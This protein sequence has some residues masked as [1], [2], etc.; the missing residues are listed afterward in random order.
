MGTH[1]RRAKK[2]VQQ[3]GR[4]EFDDEAPRTEVALDAFY[5]ARYPL[6]NAQYHEFIVDQPGEPVPYRRDDQWSSS[7]SWDQVSRR[8]PEGLEQ[9]LRHELLAYK[10]FDLSDQSDFDTV[11][12]HLGVPP[13]LLRH[14]LREK[15]DAEELIYKQLH[16]T[17]EPTTIVKDI[18][19]RLSLWID[20]PSDVDLGQLRVQVRGPSNGM[21]VNP[22]RV[23]VQLAA[24]SRV[25]ADFSVAA[26]R[27]GEFVLEVLFLD[28]DVDALRDMLP[29]Q[30]LWITS[31]TSEQQTGHI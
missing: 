7:Y 11:S 6:T 4:Q 18:Q 20:N 9:E 16:C 30:Q 19:T 2:L 27:E 31:V 22:D 10:S 14:A 29:M 23:R 17:V 15:S 24:K 3:T 21:E 25:H 13:S 12:A 8:F 28:A 26:T 5:I 1:D